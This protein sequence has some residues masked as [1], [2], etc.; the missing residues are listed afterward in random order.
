[1]I[2]FFKESNYFDFEEKMILNNLGV[3]V[4]KSRCCDL[5]TLGLK[6]ATDTMIQDT[7]NS[8]LNKVNALSDEEWEDLQNYLPFDV[9]VDD[10]D[11][12]DILDLA[13]TEE[14]G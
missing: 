6:M 10:E 8:L 7:L 3:G 14:I 9:L 4:S 5:I 13:D 1:M 11:L 12:D 2:D